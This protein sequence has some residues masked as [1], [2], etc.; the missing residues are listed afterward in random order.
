MQLTIVFTIVYYDHYFLNQPNN[1]G[2]QTG[3]LNVRK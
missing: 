2:P 1:C 3:L